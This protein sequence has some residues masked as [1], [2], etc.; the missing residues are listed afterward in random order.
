[1]VNEFDSDVLRTHPNAK[2]VAAILQQ[3]ILLSEQYQSL[4]ELMENKKNYLR[5]QVVM[6]RERRST[7]QK[8]A[9]FL[10]G[11]LLLS[12][13]NQQR[14]DAREQGENNLWWVCCVCERVIFRRTGNSSFVILIRLIFLF[15]FNIADEEWCNNYYIRA[16]LVMAERQQKPRV[17]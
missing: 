3:L 1:M 12:T 13:I 16:S 2:M 15:I 4:N 14:I 6:T 8:R 17:L 11:A 7:H 10:L 9:R 5:D